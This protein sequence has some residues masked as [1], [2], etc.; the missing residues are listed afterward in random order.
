MIG[1]L[2]LGMFCRMS[3]HT[4]SG[5]CLPDN[6]RATVLAH[7][8][9]ARPGPRLGRLLIFTVGFGL[10]DTSIFDWGGV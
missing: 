6:K 7:F 9:R 10:G 4:R 5:R 1:A 8:L 3:P 2:L